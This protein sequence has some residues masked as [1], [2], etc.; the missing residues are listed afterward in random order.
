MR[1]RIV[2]AA[3]GNPLFVEEMLAMVREDGGDEELVVPPT[4]QALLA[5][6]ARPARRGRAEVIERGAVEGKVFHRGA[7]AE[8]APEPSAHGVAGHLLRSSARS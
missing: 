2:A 7:V 6:A 5:G 1:A 4:I 8:L 3:E